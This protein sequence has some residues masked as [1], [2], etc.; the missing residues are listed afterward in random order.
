MVAKTEIPTPK[1][2]PLVNWADAMDR[3][4]GINPEV[5][6]E[7]SKTK[8]DYTE[9]FA[10]LALPTYK[11]YIEPL[12]SFLHEQSPRHEGMNTP[13]FWFQ[14]I[15]KF[16][17]GEKLT[18][19]DVA[20]IDIHDTVQELIAKNNIDLDK[21][22]ILVSEFLTNKYGGQMV[23][24]DGGEVAVYMGEGTEAEYST[25]E[26]SPQYIADNMRS[27]GTFHYSFEDPELRLAVQNLI[28]A[29]AIQADNGRF[30]NNY[31]PGYYEFALCGDELRPIF[32]DYRPD[33]LHIYR[34]VEQE[35]NS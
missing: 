9:N 16:A 11:R 19:L 5:T 28:Q 18:R 31:V 21:Y 6:A 7:L 30:E 12:A 1:Y 10:E 25:A 23:V 20:D 27:T 4:G 29:A 17:G 3:V 24:G 26:K 13:T 8:A 22:D 15:P 2:L 35:F 32:L 14:L 34:P 33:Q